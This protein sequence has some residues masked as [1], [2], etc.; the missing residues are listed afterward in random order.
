[1]KIFVFGYFGCGNLGDE[2]ILKSFSD[3]IAD[4]FPH[5]ELIVQSS[6]IAHT[7][8]TYGVKAVGKNDAP[9]MMRAIMRSRVVVAPG[10]GLLQNSTSL[11][12]LVYYL[13]LIRFAIAMGKPVYMLSQGI[14]PLEGNTARRLTSRVLKRSTHIG[15]RDEGS[16]QLLRKL[17]LP[18]KNI[19]LSGDMVLL[20]QP[21]VCCE[22]EAKCGPLPKEMPLNIGLSL[23]PAPELE[24]IIW[25]IIGCLLRINEDRGVKLHLFGLNRDDDHPIMEHFLKSVRQRA[26]DIEAE[27]IEGKEGMLLTADEME[28]AVSK[29]DVMIGMRL[30]SLVFSARCGVPFIGLS[31]DPKVAA[32]ARDCGQSVIEELASADKIELM[33]GIERAVTSRDECCMAIHAGLARMRVTLAHGMDRFRA[34]LRHTLEGQ[35]PLMGVPV[36]PLPFIGTMDYI[37]KSIEL[38]ETLH[39]VTAN[40]EMLMFGRKNRRFRELLNRTG[41]NTVDG[42]GIRLGYLLKY[43]RK[44]E[45]APGVEIMNA[46]ME[47]SR[48]RGV[49]IY[50]LGSKPE[51]I[52]KAAAAAAA[53][54]SAPIIAGHHHGYIR[55]IDPQELI[56]KINEAQPHV[57]LAGMGSPMQEEWISENLG[58]INANVFIG[59]GGSFDVL[60]GVATRAPEW[61]QKRGLEWLYRLM[62][63]PSRLGRMSVLPAYLF[64][65]TVEAMLHRLRITRN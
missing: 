59:V 15:V 45:K 27:L 16:L 40:P 52:E 9:G 24:H 8:R 13:G 5:A 33:H 36:S 50:M 20:S 55:D 62:K 38:G 2:A 42:S 56:S 51:V 10:G 26:P 54:P 21:P 12:S 28:R 65:A 58:K 35:R 53:L 44:V 6:D 48:R 23:R 22:P 25:V 18:E 57:V 31:Y 17:G 3:W 43:G 49:R 30:H 19:E 37:Y 39:V 32:F 11:K 29:L 1:M 7:E 34:V 63:D 14:G 4:N 60:A 41:L 46:L 61:M 47:E 64:L